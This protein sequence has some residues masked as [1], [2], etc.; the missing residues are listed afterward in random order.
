[1]S[2]TPW[3]KG[4]KLSA[5]HKR[6]LSEAHMGLKHTEATKQKISKANKGHK[7]SDEAKRVMSELRT[8]YWANRNK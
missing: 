3:N 8:Q 5:E 4:K 2:G 1:M 7:H 6:K